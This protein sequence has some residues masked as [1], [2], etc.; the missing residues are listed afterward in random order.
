MKDVIITIGRQFGSGGR[1]IGE[2]V[3]KKLDIPFYDEE[4]ISMAADKGGMS[5]A[6][7]EGVDEKPGSFLYSLSIATTPFGNRVSPIYDMPI[8]DKLFLLQSDVIKDVADK[9]GCVIVG[10][11]ADY[12]LR[13]RDNV[14]SAFIRSD[15]EHRI[16]RKRPFNPDV[17]ENKL[18]EIIL[19]TDKKRASYYNYYTS[20]NWGYAESYNLTID[21]GMFGI[22][23][24][25]DIIIK[26]IETVK[27][28]E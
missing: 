10:R 20:K 6:V 11:C 16:H 14:F 21:S 4:L 24:C 1:E 5:K 2:K 12:V 22:E 26:A 17:S 15:I 3:A 13:G 28:K 8:S 19:K 18:K 7:L 9:G 25:C 27:N 23:G